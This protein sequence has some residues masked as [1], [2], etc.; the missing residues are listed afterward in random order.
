MA[1]AAAPCRLRCLPLPAWGVRYGPPPR[2]AMRLHA[3]ALGA[4][5]AGRVQVSRL[6][7][8]GPAD[9]ARVRGKVLVVA[10]D[11]WQSHAGA[12]GLPRS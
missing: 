2:A 6:V 10:R 11:G 12:T 3:F 9:L 1:T 7:S 5:A 4:A 8:A